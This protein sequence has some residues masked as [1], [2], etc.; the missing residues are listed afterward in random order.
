ML[1]KIDM[2]FS[3]EINNDIAALF[4]EFK[5]CYDTSTFTATS[6]DKKKYFI[7]KLKLYLKINE[8]IVIRP[9][10]YDSESMELFFRL[11]FK[12]EQY[13]NQPDMFLYLNSDNKIIHGVI[14]GRNDKRAYY[15]NSNELF[16]I[17]TN[18]H[19]ETTSFEY[20]Y[21]DRHDDLRK[22][23]LHVH[24]CLFNELC[25]D[26]INL[27]ITKVYEVYHNPD[28]ILRFLQEYIWE[29]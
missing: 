29:Y 21:F 27:N 25:K 24:R 19:V 17:S 8:I 6:G 4:E 20:F 5:E 28:S 3:R 9:V 16:C 13:F 15:R 26:F 10:D 18:D 7:D 1:E 22:D 12:V 11:V 23:I 14:S 2:S